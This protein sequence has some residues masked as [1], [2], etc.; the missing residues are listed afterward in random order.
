MAMGDLVNTTARLASA[1]A[2][3][4]IL[5]TVAAAAAAGQTATTERRSLQPKG[6][7][8]PTDVAVLTVPGP[9]V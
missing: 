2:A 5:V 1:A 6:K 9:S 3:G 4:E 8:G 7:S